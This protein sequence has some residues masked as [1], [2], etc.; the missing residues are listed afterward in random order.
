MLKAVAATGRAASV[1]GVKA[2]GAGGVTAFAGQRCF[3]IEI[4]YGIERADVTRRV[5]T[6]GAADGRL[7]H[8]HHVGDVFVADQRAMRA[9][10]FGRLT[11]VFE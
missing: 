2:E 4:A 6:R 3:G 5:G 7:I 9:R 11:F 1:A 10:C 8:H